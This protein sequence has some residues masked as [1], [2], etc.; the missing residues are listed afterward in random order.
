MSRPSSG[1]RALVRVTHASVGVTDVM[2]VRGAYLL[3]PLRGFVPGYD[4][5]GVVEHLPAGDHSGLHVGQPVAGIMP[6]MGAHASLVRLSS[7][8]L[9]PVPE[10][11]D[12]S[13][14]ATV[15]LDA[16]TALLALD[17]L[18]ISSGSVLVQ[19]AGGAVGAWAAQLATFRGLSVL[20]T[21]SQRSRAYAEQFSA[22]V[23]DYG[24]PEWVRQIRDA[25]A[26]GVD[27]VID[28]TGSQTVRQAVRAS[29]RVVRIAFGGT[30]GRER[31]AT[32]SG[33]L[34]STLHRYGRP[35]ERICSVPVIV[36]TRRAQYRK[37]LTELFSAVSTGALVPPRPRIMAFA[38]YSD[39]LTAA[40]SA[41]P[42]EK[43][44]LTLPEG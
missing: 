2:A 43:I 20:G 6:R 1:H 21:A 25:T 4:F 31:T 15:P 7:S 29:G 42:G 41:A 40:I 22:S 39:A 28:H 30:P 5:V 34:T 37:A 35:S 44:V 11:L 32:V 8:L 16:V 23:F 19:G 17:T 13:T 3:Q 26:G 27:G 18:A 9:V 12:S 38:Q 14:A 24:D 33:F 36:A 10:L